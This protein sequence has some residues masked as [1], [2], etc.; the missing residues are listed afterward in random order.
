MSRTK[1]ADNRGERRDTAAG[2]RVRRLRINQG[3]GIRD[4]ARAIEEKGVEAGYDRERVCVS[5]DTLALLEKGHIPGPRIKFAVAHY[6]GLRPGQLWK[7]DAIGIL[8]PAPSIPPE[9]SVSA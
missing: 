5:E 9:P 4:L 7:D 1:S 3:L 8:P 2:D 6:F